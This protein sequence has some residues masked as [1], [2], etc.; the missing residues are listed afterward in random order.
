MDTILENRE[1]LVDG[2]RA[3]GDV[4][5]ALL[6]FCKNLLECSLSDQDL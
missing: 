1:E 2:T 6:F 4:A 5:A 3:L